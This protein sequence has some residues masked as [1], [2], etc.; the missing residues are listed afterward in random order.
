MDGRVVALA[1]AR[2]RLIPGTHPGGRI[3]GLC[4]HR[5]M[6]ERYGAP[7]EHERSGTQPGRPGPERPD[8]DR[9]ARE[10]PGPYL[11]PGGRG[12]GQPSDA[13]P[14]GPMAHRAYG[15][16]PRPRQ[17]TAAA[18]ICFVLGGLSMLM[19]AAVLMTSAGPEVSETLT[20]SDDAVGLV[21]FAALLTAA[22]Y[23]VPAVFAT[24]RA[25]WA[26]VAL[27]VVAVLGMAGG[28]MSLPGGLLG[29]GVHTA[30][31]ALML[32][33]PTKDWFSS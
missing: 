7:G 15:A 1:A 18:V 30:L 27:I 19:T 8:L 9:P 4:D 20:G 11:G 26:R 17:V 3:S 22:M 5:D 6:S 12:F 32:Q 16:R 24:R 13:G 33:R 29:L 31:L 25:S 10:R 2:H 28:A 23:L 14:A 21:G